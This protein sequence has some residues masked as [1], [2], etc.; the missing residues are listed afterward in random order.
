VSHFSPSLSSLLFPFP[1]PSFPRL[2]PIGVKD[3][4]PTRDFQELTRVSPLS[5]IHPLLLLLRFVS[6]RRTDG[7][8]SK[9]MELFSF[10]CRVLWDII[11]F[12]IPVSDS[13]RKEAEQRSGEGEEEG[14]RTRR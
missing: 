3:R 9:R 6:V 1:F 2:E 10:R 8:A 12:G 14:D 4:P 11:V 13:R 7:T 5:P